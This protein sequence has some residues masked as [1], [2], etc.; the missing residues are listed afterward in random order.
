MSGHWWI[1]NGEGTTCRLRVRKVVQESLRTLLNGFGMLKRE[2]IVYDC[3]VPFI[4]GNVY[5]PCLNIIFWLHKCIF[6]NGTTLGIV[7]TKA[8]VE[9]TCW[10]LGQ[11]PGTT[12]RELLLTF[13]LPYL[14]KSGKTSFAKNQREQDGSQCPQFISHRNL[15]CCISITVPIRR[16]KR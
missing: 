9:Q 14:Q 7:A 10:H 16:Y 15:V 6:I 8:H 4:F 11:M 12:N 13:I 2:R 1:V 5:A 3:Q